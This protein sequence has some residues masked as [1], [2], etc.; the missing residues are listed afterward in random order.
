MED[1]VSITDQSLGKSDWRALPNHSCTDRL[2]RATAEPGEASQRYVQAVQDH[3]QRSKELFLHS[4]LHYESFA[5]L[6][7][8]KREPNRQYNRSRFAHLVVKLLSAEKLETLTWVDPPSSTELLRAKRADNAQ[9][10][11]IRG[12]TTPA[13]LQQICQQTNVHPEFFRRHLS[14]ADRKEYFDLPSLPS[15]SREKEILRLRVTTI[16]SRSVP[17]TSAE[18]RRNR[19]EEE[20]WISSHHQ[21]LVQSGQAGDSVVRSY[22]EHNEM[23]YSLGQDI[24]CCVKRAKEGWKG[25]ST[26]IFA[27]WM[28]SE[29]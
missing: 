19:K 27:C 5:R 14:Y 9:L 1:V 18:I 24:S 20:N 3:A 28:K 12:H 21:R 26:F 16:C 13:W 8:S 11:F 17:L 25:S 15:S 4:G 29:Y 7:K 10:V 6:L 22:A 23:M 2:T